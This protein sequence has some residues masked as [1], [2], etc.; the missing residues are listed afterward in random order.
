MKCIFPDCYPFGNVTF[1]LEYLE[2][3]NSYTQTH[4]AFLGANLSGLLFLDR[5][6]TRCHGNV[7]FFFLS[8]QPQ[9]CA[10]L[11]LPTR[12]TPLTSPSARPG[13]MSASVTMAALR[14]LFWMATWWASY[15]SRTPFLGILRGSTIMLSPCP[16][17]WF[18]YTRM[19]R[20]CT[21]L[22]MSNLWSLTSWDSF[23]P[24]ENFHQSNMGRGLIL[25]DNC[26]GPSKLL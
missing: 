2:I 23:S 18:A 11:V 12:N 4:A 16:A 7:F 6:I 19:A 20:C 24:S 13:M 1:F 5:P 15:G 17:R 8:A 21:Q 9:M 14:A 3:K 25:N 26:K 22:G 10:F